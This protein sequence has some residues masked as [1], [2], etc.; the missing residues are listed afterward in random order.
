MESIL[1]IIWDWLNCFSP[2]MCKNTKLMCQILKSS[3]S[4]YGRQGRRDLNQDGLGSSCFW[5]RW[6]GWDLDVSRGNLCTLNTYLLAELPRLLGFGQTCRSRKF[7]GLALLLAWAISISVSARNT[8]FCQLKR[9]NIGDL[10]HL[11]VLFKEIRSLEKVINGVTNFTFY[12]LP[13][14][15]WH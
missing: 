13:R 12:T 1:V 10:G 6:F 7:G 2:C 3:E 14:K 15:Q 5:S 9:K 11:W 8:N 4:D